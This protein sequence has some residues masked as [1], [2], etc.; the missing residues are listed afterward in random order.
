M[1]IFMERDRFELW[2]WDVE[3]TKYKVE[4]LHEFELH[5]KGISVDYKSSA[6]FLLGEKHVRSFS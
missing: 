1:K 2:V 3:K 4:E 6:F 5:I